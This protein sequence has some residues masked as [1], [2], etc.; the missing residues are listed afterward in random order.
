MATRP[1]GAQGDQNVVQGA[2]GESVLATIASAAGYDVAFP[3]LGHGWDILVTERGPKGTAGRGQIEFQVKSWSTGTLNKDGHF[4]Y[5]LR[6][7]AY[8]DLAGKNDVRHY[9]ALCIVPDKLAEYSDAQHSHLT[10]RHAVIGYHVRNMG[11]DESLNPKSSKTVMVPA[12]NLL[13]VATIRA[14]IENKEDQ[15]VV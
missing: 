14:L 15:A 7:S 8:N 3:R 6:V 10:L 5:P 4:H 9:L 11:P 13:T 12:R 2:F 1:A